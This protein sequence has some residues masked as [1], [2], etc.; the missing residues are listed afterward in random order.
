MN[1]R[2]NTGMHH[3]RNQRTKFLFVHLINLSLTK[4]PISTSNV[5][6]RLNRVI[7][8][9]RIPILSKPSQK[10]LAE[11]ANKEE[12]RRS[13]PV[14]TPQRKTYPLHQLTL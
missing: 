12:L 7:Q 3:Q 13:L 1:K 6:T 8:V 4:L 2:K 5:I 10:D 9:Y 14:V 11:R